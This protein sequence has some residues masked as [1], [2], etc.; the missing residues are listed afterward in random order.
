MSGTFCACQVGGRAAARTRVVASRMGGAA[1]PC[2]MVCRGNTTDAATLATESLKARK[3]VLGKE[4]E[5]TLSS[6]AMVGSAYRLGAVGK[7]RRSW[8]CR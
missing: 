8:R 6:M 1:L 4:H 5:D 2:S 7:M 3:K